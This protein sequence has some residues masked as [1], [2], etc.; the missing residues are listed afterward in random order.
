MPGVGGWPWAGAV[1]IQKWVGFCS[2]I[3]V[4]IKILLASGRPALSN[5]NVT[6]ATF[7]V[8]GSLMGL[9]IVIL[10]SFL[11][12]HRH[13]KSKCFRACQPP[14]PH[15]CLAWAL[16]LVGMSPEKGQAGWH[17]SPFDSGHLRSAR[18][19]PG[20]ASAEGRTSSQGWGSSWRGRRSQARES[21]PVSMVLFRSSHPGLLHGVTKPAHL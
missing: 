19:G 1:Q 15:P 14:L 6:W 2:R 12:K 3:C 9:P 17:S 10:D 13:E 11:G 4:R 5:R 18:S 8:L 21:R 20:C 16:V 7:K